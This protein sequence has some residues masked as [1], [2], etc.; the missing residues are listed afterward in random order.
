[1][2]KGKNFNNDG[3]FHSYNN[4]NGTVQVCLIYNSHQTKAGIFLYNGQFKKSEKIKAIYP[5]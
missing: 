5:N 2:K 1:M 4:F 3:F